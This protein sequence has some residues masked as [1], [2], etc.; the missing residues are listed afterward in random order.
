M[1]R[2]EAVLMPFALG[3]ATLVRAQVAARIY[4]V[5]YLGF[6]TTNSPSDL[7]VWN[8]FVQRLRELGYSQGSNLVIEK[9][10]AKG[11]QDRGYTDFVEEMLRIKADA[12]V[13]SS[14]AMA[15]YAMGLSRTLPIVALSLPD[16]VRAGL[17]ASLARPGGQVT[18]LSD[19]SDELVPKQLELLKAAVPSIKRIAYVRC[20]WCA[21][22][23]GLSYTE[24]KVLKAEQEAAANALGI[25]LVQADLS[26]VSL[27]D[28]TTAVL[29]RERAD[30][31]LIGS[32]VLNTALRDRWQ[33]FA[34]QHRLPMLAGDRGFGA[35]LSYGPDYA[36]IYRKAAEYVAKIL[37]GAAPGD[38]PVEQPTKFD[39]VINLKTA[40]ALGIAIPQSL[41]LRAD[42]V[43]Q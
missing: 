2:R 10:Y 24:S 28:G 22:S 7:L 17:V 20:H 9:R 1:K 41:L 18:G 15:R 33:A 30:A 6:T 8:G 39:L 43:I 16:P 36:V 40:K 31:L 42:E 11:T 26:D 27:F 23:A 14:G 34:T 35:M 37:S 12:V 13:V 25:A 32:N 5:G 19:L 4:R 3:A 38:L 21:S 29:L